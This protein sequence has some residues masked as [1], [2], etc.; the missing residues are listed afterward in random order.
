MGYFSKSHVD[1]YRQENA[2][3]RTVNGDSVDT[4]TL[5]IVAERMM[6]V[7]GGGRSREEGEK[8]K[9]KAYK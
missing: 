7:V 3:G 2:G 9:A 5:M 6:E 1:R 8:S 4:A